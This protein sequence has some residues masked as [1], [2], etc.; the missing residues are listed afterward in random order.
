MPRAVLFDLEPGVVSAL[1]ALPLGELFRP[2]IRE[3]K[4]RREQQ[5]G[6]G[7]LQKGWAW[8]ILNPPCIIA[9]FVVN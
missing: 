9:A 8:V 7:P 4:R 5:L 6:Q 3:P 1:R 2:G